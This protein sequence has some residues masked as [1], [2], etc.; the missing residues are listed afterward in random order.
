MI[1]LISLRSIWEDKMNITP[2]TKPIS[3]I[4]SIESKTIYKIPFYQRNY[5]W[6][7]QNIE[8]LFNDIIEENKGYYIGN[9]LVSKKSKKDG[10]TTFDVVDGQQRLT[11][12]AL[13]FL[14][15]YERLQEFLEESDS[16]TQRAI[17][18]L[19]ND[20]SRK[21]LFEAT[22]TPKLELLEKDAEV[23]NNFLGILL[24]KDK[25]KFGNRVFGKRYY[26]IKELFDE[27][28]TYDEIFN[29]YDKLNSVEILRITVDDL[30]DAFTVFSS[31][32]AKGLPLTLIDLLKSK[33]LSVAITE[34]TQEEAMEEW[35]TLIGI[36]SDQ[37]QNANSGVITQFLLNNYD[38]FISDKGNS[39]TKSSALRKYEEVFTDKKYHYMNELTE[40]ARIY[41]Y[42]S[43]AID[44]SD[45]LEIDEDI[46][47]KLNE[48]AKLESS[49]VY[50]LLMYIL[51]KY[52]HDQMTKQTV[53][54]IV[55]YLIC[56]YVRRNIVLK[57]KASNIRAKV[58]DIIRELAKNSELD[59]NAPT[60]TKNTLNKI[61]SSDSDFYN[62]LC[63]SIYDVS[64]STAR[65]ILI[66]IERAKGGFFNKQNPDTLDS[67][68]E[69]KKGKKQLIW[70]LEHI[71]PQG[72]NLKN[73]WANM[74]SPENID[75]A[76]QI[77][78]ENTH[79]LGNLT[80]TGYN[81]EMSDKSFIIKRDYRPNEN[82]AYTGL[83]T[84]LFINSFIPN[85]EIEETIDSKST[86]TINDINRRSRKLADIAFE[87]YKIQ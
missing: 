38:T 11:T 25:S 50:P 41:S 14:A 68:N 2:E 46:I 23:Y 44:N 24:D 31:L 86:W 85:D 26:F 20:I 36:F 29:F 78:N 69:N 42:I 9:L 1:L 37:N 3:E 40:N 84:N 79:K 63:G 87:L 45:E 34:I 21:L 30:S 73:D 55:D 77:Q 15:L 10:L 54:N 28:S 43:P 56:Y 17:F 5:S 4:F 7:T 22:K 52:I 83:R 81:S 13:F 75:L 72:E 76:S 71:L 58:I 53:I 35:N 33:Y 8:D 48:L 57:P 18:G 32:N 61:I 64:P 16:K 65:F 60:I 70:T 67:F 82:S 49:Q 19:Q 62:A 59:E 47:N 51:K 80:L 27:M 12:I 74:I 6:Y 39:I 66:G